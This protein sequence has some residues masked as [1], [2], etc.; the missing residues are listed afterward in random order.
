MAPHEVTSKQTREMG[1]V[2]A[3]HHHPPLLTGALGPR[4]CPPV[5]VLSFFACCSHVANRKEKSI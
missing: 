5:V 4:P 2:P 1:L 3:R